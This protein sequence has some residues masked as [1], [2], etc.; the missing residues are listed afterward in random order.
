M[1]FRAFTLLLLFSA[2]PG[3]G[4][5][6]AAEG[7][8]FPDQLRRDHALINDARGATVLFEARSS[9]TGRYIPFANGFFI[10]KSGHILTNHHVGTNCG[11]I[12]PSS[13]FRDLSRA[14]EFPS[15]RGYLCKDFRARVFPGTTREVILTLEMIARP[16]Q[17]LLDRGG[18]FIV[19]KAVGYLP[20]AHISILQTREF[21]L[22]TPLLMVGYP[23]PTSRGH[24]SALIRRGVYTDV[25]TRG[26]YRAGY[27]EIMPAPN[28][29][30]HRSNPSPY[31]V[32]NA[33]G[34]PGVS[35]SLIISR[36]GNFLGFVQGAA[37]PRGL[38]QDPSCRKNGRPT[39]MDEFYCGGLINYQRA[40]WVLDRMDEY[41][42]STV[43]AILKR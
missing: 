12:N 41:F 2:L 23:P 25:R 1:V 13:E 16:D 22:G 6:S 29:Y 33:D 32:G 7:F 8:Y 5:S 37:D 38:G 30:F 10:S 21:P 43:Q 39:G 27:G 35:G 9:A 4:N 14:R 20:P 18:D 36:N 34:A 24:S 40:T 26:E 19:L 17:P 3:T 31:F 11:G 15:D 42:P 28:D